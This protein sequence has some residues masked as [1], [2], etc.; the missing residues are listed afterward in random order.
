MHVLVTSTC[1]TPLGFTDSFPSNSSQSSNN[2][3]SNII[4]DRG[5]SFLFF[6]SFFAAKTCS[7]HEI[8]L[9]WRYCKPANERV[10]H[11][12]SKNSG[13][14]LKLSYPACYH[15]KADFKSFPVNGI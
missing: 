13:I 14:A 4:Q 7:D 12:F 6:L 3:S 8:R 10:L 5:I 2:V 11:M 1:G 15:W 9:E